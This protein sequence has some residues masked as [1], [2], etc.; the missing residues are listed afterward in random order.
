MASEIKKYVSVNDSTNVVQ[1]EM[2]FP[3]AKLKIQDGNEYKDINNVFIKGVQIQGAEGSAPIAG[4]VDSNGVATIT[5]DGLDVEELSA[6]TLEADDIQAEE[7]IAENLSSDDVV[8][9]E[10]KAES[11]YVD[12]ISVNQLVSN[13]GSLKDLDKVEGSVTVNQLQGLYNSLIEKLK[14]LV[15]EPTVSE[16]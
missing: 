4:S 8:A 9:G 5:I 3:D 6:S 13:L 7:I 12:G 10:I 16:G 11:L 2:K 15:P 14:T 1:G